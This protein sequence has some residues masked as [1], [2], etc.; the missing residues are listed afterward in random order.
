MPNIAY[1][2]G[3]GEL[4]Y[5][6][7]Y[8]TMFETLGV[9]FPILQLRASIMIIDKNQDQKL[10]KLGIANA[11]I[12]KS[13]QELVNFIV[14]SKGESIEL[15]E[16]K[17]KAEAIFNELQKKTTDIDKTLENLVKAELQ[18]TLN[19]I[20]AIEAKLN[21]SLKQRSETEINQ[22]KNI[23]S[24]LF[25][26]NTPQERYD[27]FSMYYAKYGKGFIGAVKKQTEGN[28]LK[29]FVLREV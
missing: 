7:E 27:N 10:N 29:Y 8:K 13:E 5:W 17:K 25:P 18:K 26:D 9:F 20:N 2:G 15:G 12:F 23:R 28:E 11:D 1:V 21:K 4:N 19:S 24:K 3:P 16:E 6:L 22:I 14:E